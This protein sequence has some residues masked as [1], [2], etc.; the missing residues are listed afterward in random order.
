MRLPAARGNKSGVDNQANR[1]VEP[2]EF[3]CDRVHEERHVVSDNQHHTRTG[4]VEDLHDG[5]P[6]RTLSREFAVPHRPILEYLPAVASGVL[7]REVFIVVP[8]EIL[9]G[10]A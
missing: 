7:R 6:R 1:G 8:D 5:L 3:G 9:G 2:H 4:L 10:C